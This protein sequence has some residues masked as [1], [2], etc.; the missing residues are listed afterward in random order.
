MHSSLR[1]CRSARFLFGLLCSLF[2]LLGTFNNLPAARAAAYKTGHGNP[3]GLYRIDPDHSSV[4]FAVGH[5]GVGTVIGRF[6]TIRGHY[7][8]DPGHVDVKI[9][10]LSK[11][12][13]T[14]HAK[15]DKD[16]RGPDFLDSRTFPHIRFVATT[17]KKTGRMSGVLTGKLTIRGKTR[18]VSLH[19]REVGAADVSALPKPW[20]GYLT[21]Y[22][23]EGVIHRKDFGITTYP[24]M[25]GDTVHL[26]IDVEGV[27]VQ[28]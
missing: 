27:R 13:D 16:L 21:G 8:L 18:T 26:Y 22:D 28:K 9:D 15:R 11:S 12:I 19:V 23:A 14:N 10:I 17:Y 5:A 6:D 4:V 2:V 1:D 3:A 20:G 25:I 7:R 24:A